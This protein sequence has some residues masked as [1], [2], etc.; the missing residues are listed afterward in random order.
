LAF[1]VAAAIAALSGAGRWLPLHL[2]LTGGLVLAISGVTVMLTVS[3]SAAPAPSDRVV[4]FQR[5]CVA[6]GALGLAA[7]RQLD[8]GRAVLAVA[9]AAYLVGLV[10]LAVVLVV[11]VRRGVERR[12]DVAVVAYVAALV[13]G[14]ASGAAGLAMAIL[15]SEPHL[16]TAHVI[17]NLLGLVGLV[18][19]GT[20]PYFA[21]TV[22]RARMATRAT[23]R[24]LLGA[25]LWQVG[26]LVA[27]AVAAL[28][29]APAVVAA[30]LVAYAVGVAGVVS[31]LPHPTRRQL[32]WAGPRLVA[33][34]FGVVWWALAVAVTAADAVDGASELFAGRWLLVLVVGGYLQIFWGSLAYLLPVLRGGGHEHLS[35]GFAATRSWIGLGAANL[36]ALA[37]GF[38]ASDLA[39]VALTVWLVDTAVRVGRLGL[40]WNR[41]GSAGQ[42]GGRPGEEGGRDGNVAQHL[43]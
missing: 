33:L 9:G 22:G 20:L 37:L 40:G 41:S 30:G 29:E 6:L 38:D 42:E 24:R 19:F 39:A 16:R 13:A 4:L 35:R 1:V 43:G 18:V 2:A 14:T 21:A 8:L 25:T 17:L 3:W 31:L 10:V 26:A 23:S 32:R 28:V 15:P 27:A 36:A 5:V 12:F 34:W 7:G 11:T